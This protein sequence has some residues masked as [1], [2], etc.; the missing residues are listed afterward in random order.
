MIVGTL[1]LNGKT[2]RVVREEDYRAML[3]AMR[4]HQRQVKQD[5]ADAA[6]AERR[7]KRSKRKTIPLAQ[8]KAELAQQKPPRSPFDVSGV[9]TGASTSD[10]LS[11]I[12]SI[13]R[14]SKRGKR[15]VVKSAGQCGSYP[16]GRNGGS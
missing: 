1:R 13:R 6:E 12:R 2:Y 4:W 15:Q 3:A 5:A 14:S 11:A 10:I 7:R 16:I 8:L 9:K